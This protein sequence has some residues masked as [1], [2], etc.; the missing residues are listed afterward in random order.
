L[1]KHIHD[2]LCTRKKRIIP[3]E[4][5]REAAVLIPLTW[6][7][8]EPFVI[9]T[10]RSMSMVHH[11]GE[12][13]FPGGSIESD[14]NDLVRTAL[15]ETYEE[16]G[17]DP[18][19]VDVLGLLDDHISIL[20]YHI[21]PVVGTVPHPYDFRINQESDMLMHVPLR[22]VLSDKAWMAERTVYKDREINIYYLPIDGGVIWGATGR[23]MKH[24]VDL[25]AGTRIP[26]GS[27]SQEVRTWI[28]DLL[29]SQSEYRASE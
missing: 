9:V 10:K 4:N 19:D 24:F 15:R 28:E 21:T 20:G 22:L 25:I 11:K 27:V 6:N 29:V 3:P 14:D 17:L 1:K 18:K 23:I 5:L 7:K 8:G 16:I 13:S 2:I 12:F 26:F